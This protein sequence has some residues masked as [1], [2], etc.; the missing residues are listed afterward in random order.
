MSACARPRRSSP[1][2]PTDYLR[3]LVRCWC[4]AV[5]RRGQSALLMAP[6]LRV[7][8]RSSWRGPHLGAS[9]ALRPRSCIDPGKQVPLC[10]RFA[11]YSK[12]SGQGGLVVPETTTAGTPLSARSEPARARL[13]S[14]VCR[15]LCARG[16][17]EQAPPLERSFP[18]EIRWSLHDRARGPTGFESA[19][20]AGRV[21]SSCGYLPFIVNYRGPVSR[22]APR[23]GRDVP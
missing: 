5:H 10:I 17:W 23:P 15:P 12:K 8:C 2:R 16:S 1:C 4:P 3:D 6:Q 11:L 14:G 7:G 9:N 22:S 13:S 18:R 19:H 21:R 20:R